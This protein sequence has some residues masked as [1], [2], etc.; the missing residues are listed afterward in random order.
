MIFH[1]FFGAMSHPGREDRSS[2]AIGVAHR[3]GAALEVTSKG[4]PIHP[5]TIYEN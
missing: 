4:Q 2:H 1:G 3:S 5:V